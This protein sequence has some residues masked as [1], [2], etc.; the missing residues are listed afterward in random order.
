MQAPTN[1]R[2][3]EIGGLFPLEGGRRDSIVDEYWQKCI[4]LPDRAYPRFKGVPDGI[5]F[6]PIGVRAIPAT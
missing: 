2:D 6:E 1:Q 5:A 4:F 3:E